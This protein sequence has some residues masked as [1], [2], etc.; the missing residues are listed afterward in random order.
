MIRKWIKYL[1]FSGLII[2]MGC[3]EEITI[4]LPEGAD[5]LVVEG[6]IEPNMP[7]IVILT[8]TMP[9][10][11]KTDVSTL[12][13]IYVSGADI[14]VSDGTKT[15]NLFELNFKN[16]PD[17]IAGFLS[18]FLQLSVEDLKKLDFVIY[19]TISMFGETGKTYSLS[20]VKDTFRL[21]AKTTIPKPVIPDS[22]WVEHHPDPKNDSLKLIK[23]TITDRA[24]EKNYYRYFTSVNNGAYYPNRFRSVFDDKLVDGQSLIVPVVRGEPRVADFNPLTYGVYKLGD[25]VS[26]KLCTIDF[27]HYTFWSTF[28]NSVSS[29]GP[30]AVPVQ[31]KSNIKGGLG[32]WGGYGAVY[33]QIIVK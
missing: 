29:G 22:L 31:I 13:G 10:F 26:V 11:S 9:Y 32:I 33:R 16:L 14:K 1:I 25:T 21:E 2:L 12:S 8:R 19:T 28:E 5:Q 15:V 30:Y 27:D 18:A 20:I 4:K 23:M 3:E 17:S 6:F 24:G 7:P